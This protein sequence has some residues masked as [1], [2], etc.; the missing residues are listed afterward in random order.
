M[1]ALKASPRIGRRPS[2][3]RRFTRRTYRKAFSYLMEEFQERCAY[4]DQHVSRAGGSRSMEIDHFDPT[5]KSA[6]VQ[7]YYNL[8]LATRHCNSAKSDFWPTPGDLRKGLRILNPTVE[9]DWG[10][11]VVEDPKTHRLWG[12]TPTGTFHIRLLD[13][14]AEHLV[15]ERR[16]RYE[17]HRLLH[18]HPVQ[19]RTVLFELP[20]AVEGIRSQLARMIRLIPQEP[21][22]T[23]PPALLSA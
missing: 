3:P 13:L 9:M 14:N 17:L 18:D 1:P 15:E 11:H 21:Q 10:I 2:A 16:Q 6:V 12:K 5:Q 7:D 19:I 20:E 23:L 8:L 22:A 4:S